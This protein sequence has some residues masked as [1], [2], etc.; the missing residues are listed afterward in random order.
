MTAEAYLLVQRSPSVKL[1][2][3]NEGEQLPIASLTK[4]MTLLGCQILVKLFKIR[5]KKTVLVSH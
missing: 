5:L 4:M 3:K 2:Y 1:M